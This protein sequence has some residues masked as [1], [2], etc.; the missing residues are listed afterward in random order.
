MGVYWQKESRPKFSS[1]ACSTYTT[2]STIIIQ[3]PIIYPIQISSH[4]HHN[5]PFPLH[6]TNILSIS[7]IHQYTHYS[8]NWLFS[9]SHPTILPFSLTYLTIIPNFSS[10]KG[11]LLTNPHPTIFIRNPYPILIKWYILAGSPLTVGL[12]QSKIG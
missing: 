1:I 9:L 7:I 4:I 10:Y 5:P 6:F 8:S 12:I 2:D 3:F 11:V